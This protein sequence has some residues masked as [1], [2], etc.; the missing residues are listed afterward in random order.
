[1]SKKIGRGD[2][3]VVPQRFKYTRPPYDI[4]KDTVE[5]ISRIAIGI[6]IIAAL[7]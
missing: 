7:D 3:I 2:T 4:F 5:M 6:G 1:M